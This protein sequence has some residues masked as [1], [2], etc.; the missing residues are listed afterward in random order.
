MLQMAN[1]RLGFAVALVI[2]V[3]SLALLVTGSPLLNMTLSEALGLPLGTVLTWFGMM[4]LV[5]MIWFGSKD[6]R[7]P[8]TRRDRVYR[9]TW[10]VLLALAVLWPFVSYAL[11]G[12]WSFSFRW[13][14]GFRG[15][16]RAADWFFRYSYAVVLLPVLFALVRIAHL[17]FARR[18]DKD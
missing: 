14:E 4:A 11:A 12:N 9:R 7:Q 13:Q 15:S 5:M 8:A 1:I 17:G 18:L 10:F 6:L 16:S 3:T 2:F